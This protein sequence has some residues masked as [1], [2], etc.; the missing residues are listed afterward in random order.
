MRLAIIICIVFLFSCGSAHHEYILV[1]KDSQL[2]VTHWLS[3]IDSTTAF[4]D[5]YQLPVDSLKFYLLRAKGIIITG[6][7]DVNPELYQ[8]P[9][10]AEVCGIPDNYRDSL[11]TLL[12][13]FAFKNKV[14]LLGICRGN[15]ILNVVNGG[16]LIPDI[17]S[18]VQ[19]SILH[20][21]LSDSAHQVVIEPKTRLKW[22]V[23]SDTLWVNSRHH[24]C[25][26]QLAPGF[27]VSVKAPDGII[28]GIELADSTLHPFVIGVQWHPEGLADL[29]SLRI[30]KQFL[31]AANQY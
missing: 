16:T 15:Q 27:R 30:G 17:P 22:M 21:S 6:G 31:E 3:A 24:Q 4:K 25:I 29:A 13:R 1:S 23:E 2:K 28:E 18:F 12:I 8:K 5:C 19:T 26:N 20:L 9:D 11:E 14:P 7:E 10:Y